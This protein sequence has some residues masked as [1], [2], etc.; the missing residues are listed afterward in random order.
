[1]NESTER[2]EPWHRIPDTTPGAVGYRKVAAHETEGHTVE[3]KLYQATV[4]LEARDLV[5]A[6]ALFREVRRVCPSADFPDVKVKVTLEMGGVPE[7]EVA[8]I[9]ALEDMSNDVQLVDRQVQ[10][11]YYLGRPN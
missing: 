5:T 3:D 1:M 9:E 7:R 11:I 4:E 6:L 10:G 2:T 8:A